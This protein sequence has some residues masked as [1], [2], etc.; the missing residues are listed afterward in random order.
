MSYF[1]TALLS[2]VAVAG[3][4]VPSFAD[5]WTA[6]KLRGVVVGLFDGEWVKLQRG[7]VI[8]DNQPIRTLASGRVTFQRGEETI[9]LGPHTQVQ[10]FDRAGRAKHTTV[11]Q[12]FGKVAVEAEVRAVNHFSVQT[13]YLAAVVKGTRFVVISGDRGA[14]VQVERGAVAVESSADRSSV[15]V[16]AGQEV[17]AT[18]GAVM[19]VSGRG[20]LP[21]VVDANGKPVNPAAAEAR[22]G[23][24]RGPDKNGPGGK[25]KSG[26]GNFSNGKGPGNFGE[27]AKNDSGNGNG[28]GGNSGGGNGNSGGNGNGNSGNGG[29]NGNSGNSGKDGGNG[30]SGGNGKTKGGD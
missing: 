17:S 28:G 10:I 1:R 26:K 14:R 16:A 29:G 6:V 27:K 22:N 23:E 20:E 5:D 18:P 11:K 9:D 7:A 4:T 8:P 2:A 19:E 30:N 13:P 3:L 15:V 24:F 12:Y 25:G 21:Q